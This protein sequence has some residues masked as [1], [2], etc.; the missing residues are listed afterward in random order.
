MIDREISNEWDRGI[1]TQGLIGVLLV[2]VTLGAIIYHAWADGAHTGFADAAVAAFQNGK[3]DLRSLFESND[4]ERNLGPLRRRS[5]FGSDFTMA[6]MG[7]VYFLFRVMRAF[8]RI[9]PRLL[10]AVGV[11]FA[12]T[13]AARSIMQSNLDDAGHQAVIT[14]AT[15]NSINFMAKSKWMLLFM[16][17]LLC[18]VLLIETPLILRVGGL[19]LAG[20]SAAG[21]VCVG[22]PLGPPM[23]YCVLTVFSAFSGICILLLFHPQLAYMKFNKVQS[24]LK[25]KS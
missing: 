14:D 12:F 18:G 7:F 11:T 23:P 22:V 20:A 6:W 17:A 19:I 25:R 16:D 2:L 24:K 8:R 13:L 4:S 10:I 21:I 5:M 15:L 1:R 9:P 3:A